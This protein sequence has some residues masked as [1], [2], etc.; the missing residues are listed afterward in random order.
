MI[1]IAIV[2][3]HPA[4]RTGLAAL[5]RREPSF[6]LVVSAGYA[7]EARSGVE[8]HPVEV[9]LADFHLPDLDGISLCRSLKASGH[10]RAALL[11]SAF[12][13]DWLAIAARIGGLDGLVGKGVAAGE[14]FDALRRAAAGVPSFPELSPAQMRA[15]SDLIE[16]DDQPMLGML[17][18]GASEA[19]IG[20]VLKLS[21]QA[22]S[23]R[24][25]RM[26]A[27]LRP[28]ALARVSPSGS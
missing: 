23:I 7:A 26:L 15:A 18:G 19:E 10:C 6:A 17:M 14:V 13:G 2:D 8:A 5:I 9:V 3:D 24:V 11:Y 25:D 12:A 4:V 28:R 16:P 21:P 22:V 20:P 1:S 27:A